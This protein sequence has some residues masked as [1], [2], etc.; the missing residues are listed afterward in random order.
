MV[1]IVLSQL[2]VLLIITV[3]VNVLLHLEELLVLLFLF[4]H[5]AELLV[6]LLLFD[7]GRLLRLL[8]ARSG[9]VREFS[10][11]SLTCNE[12][13]SQFGSLPLALTHLPLAS[14]YFLWAV[15]ISTNFCLAFSLARFFSALS[16]CL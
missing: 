3:Q 11:K 6:L 7:A 1:R 8:R 5:L 10:C 9:L 14:S 15:M 12:L 16:I 4:F 13:R 2:A